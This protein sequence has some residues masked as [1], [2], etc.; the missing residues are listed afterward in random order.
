[1]RMICKHCGY[2]VPDGAVMCPQCGAEVNA[3]HRGSPGAAG[4]RQGRRES[5]P[6][7]RSYSS[8]PLEDDIPVS[9][10]VLQSRRRP[11]SEEMD[12]PVEGAGPAR[13]KRKRRQT[14]VRRFAVN[15]AL[16]WVIVIILLF[17]GAAGVYAYLKVTP[18]GQL[19]LARMGR[20]ANATAL[21]TY[22]QELYDQGY[23]DRSIA[24]FEK[25]YAQEP[26]REDIYDRLRQLADVYENSGRVADAEAIYIRLYTEIDEK[27]PLAYRDR[28]RVLQEQDRLVELSSF[29][30]MAYEKTGD[31]YFQR[32]REALIPAAP[33]ASE[34][35]GTR[36]V[37]IDV[38]LLSD[39]DYDI[40]YLFGD[41]GILPD[42]GIKY[43]AP[44]HL[45]EGNYIL[46]AV[47]VSSDLQ[48]DELRITYSVNLLKPTAPVTT[49]A[50]GEYKKRYA[51]G[52]NY[53][54]GEDEEKSEDP[55]I[56]EITIYY[57]VDG[58][59]PNSNSP[60]FT[61][62]KFL[63]P[64]GSS[65]I[66]AVAVNGYGKVSNIMERTFKTPYT[67]AKDKKYFSNEDEFAEFTLM[68]T[69][70][71]EFVK[72]F[73]APNAEAPVIDSA[74]TGECTRLV[75][76]WGEARF[77]LTE[78]GYVL[79]HIATASSSMTG[80][81]KTKIGMTETEVT[82][83]FRDMGQAHDQ[84][85]DRSLYNSAKGPPA[86]AFGKLYHIDNQ[87]DRIDY[88]YIR[89]DNGVVTLSYD[90]ENSKVVK[91]TLRCAY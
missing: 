81:Q 38:A 11:R 52:L 46:R 14:R 15:W 10:A 39:S 70:R 41:E 29:L 19:I 69:S 58:Q 35:A 72:R 42:D 64:A 53:V 28:E 67:Y 56:H 91:I 62:E 3:A 51:I 60:I 74:M 26:D 75:Y 77:S 24:T 12:A 20:D 18:Q 79:Y 9:D 61:G 90:L 43:T 6:S 78:N 85:G 13:K 37:E 89:A 49:L 21:W 63:L 66:K 65:V 83:S 36:R 23:L 33:T 50:P 57:T 4:M 80:P 47:S 25:A 7:E 16:L 30:Q 2:I 45:A 5:A 87:H 54:P 86:G 59:T 55:K 17:L 82:G 84:N 27:N 34:E 68:K 73:G 40:Y 44:I 88:S 1:M 76:T 48:S 8:M 31:S 71:E 32:Q 22:G